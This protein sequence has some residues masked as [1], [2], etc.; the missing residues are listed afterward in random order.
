MLVYRLNFVI[1]GEKFLVECSVRSKCHLLWGSCCHVETSL[2][3]ML[4]PL[5]A[6]RWRHGSLFWAWLEPGL[7]PSCL[8]CLSNHHL[9]YPWAHAYKTPHKSPSLLSINTCLW[10]WKKHIL[11]VCDLRDEPSFA[12]HFVASINDKGNGYILSFLWASLPP[13]EQRQWPFAEWT[14]KVLKIGKQLAHSGPQ[15]KV[16]PLLCPKMSVVLGDCLSEDERQICF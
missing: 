10:K 14:V 2:S 7:W 15:L 6:I 3:P 4:P 5:G 9:R 1:I 8:L 13:S 16:R 12:S 11:M